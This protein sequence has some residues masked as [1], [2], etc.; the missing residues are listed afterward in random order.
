[1][2]FEL[3]NELLKKS[4]V[5]PVKT[6]KESVE[7]TPATEVK[8]EESVRLKESDISYAELDNLLEDAMKEGLQTVIKESN[9]GQAAYDVV[10]E[11]TF[12]EEQVYT[13]MND[14]ID[15]IMETVGAIQ[16]GKL[17]ETTGKVKGISLPLYEIALTLESARLGALTM[18]S[19]DD[20]CIK[21]DV[22]PDQQELE[23]II[24][25][26]SNGGV[27][28]DTYTIAKGEMKGN[29]GTKAQVQETTIAKLTDVQQQSKNTTQK[30]PKDGG[31]SAPKQP[32]RNSGLPNSEGELF[33]FEGDEAGNPED[34]IFDTFE[35]GFNES[36][37]MSAIGR[38]YSQIVEAVRKEEEGLDTEYKPNSDKNIKTYG[39]KEAGKPKVDNSTITADGTAENT[40]IAEQQT[41]IAKYLLGR[42]FNEYGI[43]D[44]EI[45]R[46]MVREAIHYIFKYGVKNLLPAVSDVAQL[47]T[48]QNKLS[49]MD[50]SV[51]K[52]S[53][54]VE[55]TKPS[56]TESQIDTILER[57]QFLASCLIE[58]KSAKHSKNSPRNVNEKEMAAANSGVGFTSKESKDGQ[59]VKE[60]VSVVECVAHITHASNIERTRQAFRYRLN[61]FNESAKQ[62]VSNSWVHVDT[63]LSEAAV[64]LKPLMTVRRYVEEAADMKEYFGMLKE[65]SPIF[66]SSIKKSVLNNDSLVAASIFTEVVSIWKN[67]KTNMYNGKD[68]DHKYVALSTMIEGVENYKQLVSAVKNP[69][70]VKH[71]LE[72]FNYRLQSLKDKVE[73]KRS[74][75]SSKESN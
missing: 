49:D 62:A 3:L 70:K 9:L 31:G 15:P 66:K 71:V 32:K 56:L 57:G 35:D 51:N 55:A 75:Q 46:T 23:D 38:V 58:S 34:G 36:D 11:S 42:I 72:N 67:L 24:T 19:L 16:S 4:G 68:L 30:L 25:A 47:V 7:T 6:V 17:L 41:T 52:A 59:P 14:T 64:E 21:E 61:K 37:E 48:E 5:E 53:A 69:D 45:R 12:D 50:G 2:A 54:I 22:D 73:Y 26:I 65:D 44:Q 39:G 27:K 33:D 63:N 1:M 18:E 60:G 28:D 74:S 13:F 29:K 8:H 40:T 10:S 43:K 20:V